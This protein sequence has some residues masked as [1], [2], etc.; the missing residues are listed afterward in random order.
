MKRLP[1]LLLLAFTGSLLISSCKSGDKSN[2]PVPADAIF[3]MH[4]NSGALS[5]KLP[6][7]EIKATNWFKDAY[8]E[9][10]DT[11]LR[12]LLDDPENSGIDTKADLLMFVKS[13]GRGGYLAFE[14][15]L[16]DAAAFEAFNKKVTEGATA[17]KDGDA[18]IMKIKDDGIVFWQGTRFIYIINAP[19]G[20]IKSAASGNYQYGNDYKFS[21]DSL[22][23]F[24]KGTFALSGKNSL[25][26]D[27]RYD[28]LMKESADMHFWINNEKYFDLVGS[29][30]LAVLKIADLF[31][32]NVSTSTLNFDNGKI[33]IKSKS[34]LNDQWAKIYKNNPPKKI[35][36]DVIDRIPSQNVVGVLA[37]NYSPEG[38]KEVI[39]LTGLDGM[40]NGFLSKA[41]YSIEEFV[42]AN[43]GD[44][45]LSV[46]DFSMKAKEVV[47]PS[48]D[49]GEPTKYTTTSPDLRV[50]FATSVNDKAA[51]D[52]L[53]TTLSS[54]M[55]QQPDQMPKI[56]YKIDNNWF[57]AGNAEEDVMKFMTGA[58][59]SHPFTS[60]LKDQTFG[61]YVDISKLFT[62]MGTSTRDSS[63]QAAYDASIKMWQDALMT[64]GEF[65]DGAFISEAEVNLVD[66]NTNSLK[67]LNQYI[68]KMAGIYK[69][70]YKGSRDVEVMTPPA[71]VVDEEVKPQ[72]N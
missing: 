15:T 42:K 43:K 64:G 6:W 4:I 38:L 37:I 30:E 70:R 20:S 5:S 69:N 19:L 60:K 49:G 23:Q 31:K 3:V 1:L 65:K 24:A 21:T 17:T 39:K 44:L 48:Y 51:F 25:G 67:Q 41:N 16:K 72:S 55:G 33:T 45:V 32:G 56:T 8:A 57:V 14:G 71:P 13:E 11:L 35:S 54:E 61:M 68:D 66:K 63:E 12:K 59:T 46:S 18:S 9:A 22:K 53:I 2:T 36:A 34:Y 50:L 62:G 26:A 27:K 10:P 29:S 7:S 47:I 28:A 40:L 58:K 52:K